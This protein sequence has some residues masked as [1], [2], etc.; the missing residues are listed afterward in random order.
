MTF[1]SR[2]ASLAF[3]DDQDTNPSGN[4]SFDSVLSARMSRRT[5][6]KGTMGVAASAFFG[7]SL[8]GCSDDNYDPP[9]PP[10]LKLDF[11]AVGKS[12]ADAVVVPPGYTASVLFRLGD[13]IAA[14]V[15]DYLNNGTDPGASYALRAGDHHDGIHYFGMGAGGTYNPTASDRGLL[16]M[17]HEAI[18]PLFLHV[19]GPTIVS[20][21][22]TVND[23]VIKASASSKSPRPAAR[24][25]TTSPRPTTAASP[26]TPR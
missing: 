15:A 2:T 10:Q 4:P 14:G 12:L 3:D 21:A 8:A 7:T 18:S 23:E 25:R 26:R 20:G 19:S 24:S 17:N 13:P 11:T 1:E 6:L 5:L 16:V 22:R 9:P